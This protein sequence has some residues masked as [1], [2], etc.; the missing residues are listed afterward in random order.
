MA[1]G[2]IAI[3]ED[4]PEAVRNIERS[5]SRRFAKALSKN[6]DRLL[7]LAIE[8]AKASKEGAARTA[9]SSRERNSAA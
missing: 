6:P 3:P 5:I 8:K 4:Q 1:G 2:W 7:P 9:E